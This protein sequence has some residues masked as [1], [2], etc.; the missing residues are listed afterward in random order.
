MTTGGTSR[1]KNNGDPIWPK[2]LETSNSSSKGME[3]AKV[4][5]RWVSLLLVIRSKDIN[6]GVVWDL[7]DCW[8]SNEFLNFVKLLHLSWWQFKM[9]ILFLYH[10]ERQDVDDSF[11]PPAQ[12]N[13]SSPIGIFLAPSS[14]DIETNREGEGPDNDNIAAWIEYAYLVDDDREVFDE[15]DVREPIDS[16]EKL[17]TWRRSRSVDKGREGK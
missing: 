6:A 8:I 13:A 16:P 7:H 9:M 4:G 15:E 1:L 17:L 14:S 11:Q 10:R 5:P 3:G 2:N 12:R